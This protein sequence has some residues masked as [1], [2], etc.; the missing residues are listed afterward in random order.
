MLCD[1]CQSVKLL[2][3]PLPHLHSP[4]NHS[5]RRLLFVEIRISSSYPGYLHYA[6]D[7]LSFRVVWH[8]IQIPF[9][10]LRSD[11]TILSVSIPR[12]EISETL[13]ATPFE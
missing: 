12:Q 3:I 5:T 6:E 13:P 4:Q 8:I 1:V 9:F 2:H 11:S 7:S 10:Q